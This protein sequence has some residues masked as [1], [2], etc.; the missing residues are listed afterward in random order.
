MKLQYHISS[1]QSAAKSPAHVC[2]DMALL[3]LELKVTNK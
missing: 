1:H 3:V 2:A